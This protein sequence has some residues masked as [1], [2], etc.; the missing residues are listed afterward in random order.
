M[1]YDSNEIPGKA[2]LVISLAMSRK[3]AE[4]RE[5]SRLDRTADRSADRSADNSGSPRCK[6]NLQP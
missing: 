3:N 5:Y 6:W 1:L 2:A 4:E